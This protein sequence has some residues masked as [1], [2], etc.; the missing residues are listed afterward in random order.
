MLAH[1]RTLYMTTPFP[2]ISDA[3]T[4]TSPHH[5]GRHVAATAMH[6]APRP[7]NLLPEAEKHT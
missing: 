7:P 3:R 4:P 5:P 1:A 2:P 6:N